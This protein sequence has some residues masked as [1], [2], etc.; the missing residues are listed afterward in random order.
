MLTWMR[1][2]SGLQSLA[3]NIIVCDLDTVLMKLHCLDP[4]L[5]T[6]MVVLL[7]CS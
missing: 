2:G 5:C 3:E 4:I 6:E 1:I 7:A